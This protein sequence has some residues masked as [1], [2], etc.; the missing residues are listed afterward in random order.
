MYH[1]SGS[2]WPNSTTA[3]SKHFS[4][5]HFAC[6]CSRMAQLLCDVQNWII[7]LLLELFS[8]AEH[9]QTNGHIVSEMQITLY[10]IFVIEQLLT[11][12]YNAVSYDYTNL[13]RVLHCNNH[14]SSST[15]HQIHSPSHALHHLTLKGNTN[16][17]VAIREQHIHANQNTFLHYKHNIS[18]CRKQLRMN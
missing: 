15:G 17:D 13:S 7:W 10:N 1:H 8:F 16:K 12:Q 4:V 11:S 2:F 6:L 9:K 18:G 5:C 3:A 14:F